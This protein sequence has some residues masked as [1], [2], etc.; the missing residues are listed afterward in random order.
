[1][2]GVNLDLNLLGHIGDHCR[3]WSEVDQNTMKQNGSEWNRLKTSF[4]YLF[5]SE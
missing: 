1:M 5:G 2:S 4:Y 3:E